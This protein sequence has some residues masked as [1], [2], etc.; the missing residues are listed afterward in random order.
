MEK[1]LWKLHSSPQVRCCTRRKG[2]LGQWG[3]ARGREI[4]TRIWPGSQ[5]DY[6]FCSN[7]L[8][9]PVGFIFRDPC[10][11]LP[12]KPQADSV[13]PQ[14]LS[15]LRPSK[16]RRKVT[17]RPPNCLTL[18][19]HTFFG[20][21]LTPV[22]SWTVYSI[23]KGRIFKEFLLFKPKLVSLEF[24]LSGSSSFTYFPELGLIPPS[25]LTSLWTDTNLS[26]CLLTCHAQY[27]T[28]TLPTIEIN[29]F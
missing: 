20:D 5:D 23:T 1:E 2:L 24:L 8:Q 14:H 25:P 13:G 17:W 26:L 6:G 11:C 4:S 29:F 27:W 21:E 10:P 22:L 18:P 3:Q 12:H 16:T 7:S 28:W 9:V 15:S 19:L